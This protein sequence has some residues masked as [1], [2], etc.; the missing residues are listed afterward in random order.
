VAERPEGNSHTQPFRRFGGGSRRKIVGKKKG[1]AGAQFIS[2]VNCLRTDSKGKKGV[3][4]FP[5]TI[6]CAEETVNES[7]VR[8]LKRKGGGYQ[9]HRTG[10][11][12]VNLKREKVT[13]PARKKV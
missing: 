3:S 12:V 4:A 11:V 6:F 8:K 9:V 10:N 13:L 2:L 1:E 7:C 5:C